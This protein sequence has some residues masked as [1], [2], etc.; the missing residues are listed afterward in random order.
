[1]GE[2]I[3]ILKKEGSVTIQ[4]SNRGRDLK[5]SKTAFSISKDGGDGVGVYVNG[6]LI[7]NT[8]MSNIT[9]QDGKS[10]TPEQLRPANWYDLTDGLTESE[11]GGG[12]MKKYDADMDGVV[13]DA[14]RL[15][16]TLPEG[17]VR[18]VDRPAIVAESIEDSNATSTGYYNINMVLK[19]NCLPNSVGS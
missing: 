11:G 15:G 8:E 2:I 4:L 7:Y 18:E 14:A 1:M 9:V 13:D 19:K 5:L 6:E 17:Y 3:N 12:G 10:A 16:G